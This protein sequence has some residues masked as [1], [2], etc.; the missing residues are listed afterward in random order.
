MKL[1]IIGSRTITNFDP[2]G[3]IPEETDLIISG[4]AKGVDRVAEQYADSHGI[5][6]LIILPQY[7]KFGR[8][9]PLKR[10]EEMVDLADTVL[11]IWDG[12]SR[13]TKYTLN[14]AKKKNKEIIEIIVGC[15]G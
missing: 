2:A 15:E 14:Y 6:K 1:L 9:A 3:Y 4:G 7:E 5:E 12:E 10:N 11:A 8:A 13:G